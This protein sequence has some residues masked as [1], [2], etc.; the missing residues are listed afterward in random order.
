[1]LLQT[2]YQKKSCK[3]LRPQFITAVTQGKKRKW[4]ELNILEKIQVDARCRRLSSL[5]HQ[6]LH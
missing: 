4:E 1:M 3:G 5:I 6:P 2:G